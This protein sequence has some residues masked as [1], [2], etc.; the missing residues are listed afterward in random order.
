MK[1]NIYLKIN[2][3]YYIT[4]IE[5]I[6]HHST[7]SIKKNRISWKT[8]DS[9]KFK[10]IYKSIHVCIDN[11]KSITYSIEITHSQWLWK[12]TIDSKVFIIIVSQKK[13]KKRE[14]EEKIIYRKKP[15]RII[16]LWKHKK[17]LKRQVY[18]MN[19]RRL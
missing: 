14:K 8:I 19:V 13:K 15:H 10:F 1:K 9:D 6:R 7:Q 18:W 4:N 5:F 12:S 2:R 11:W 3:Y 16:L 17:V